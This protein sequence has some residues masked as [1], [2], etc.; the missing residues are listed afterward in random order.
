M[1]KNDSIYA[2]FQRFIGPSKFASVTRK[3]SRLIVA[4]IIQ[5]AYL[6]MTYDWHIMFSKTAH[7][8]KHQGIYIAFYVLPLLNTPIRKLLVIIQQE[9]GICIYSVYEKTTYHIENCT[10]IFYTHFIWTLDWNFEME[11]LGDSN[12]QVSYSIENNAKK[13]LKCYATTYQLG[14]AYKRKNM[15]R[16]A[17][18]A[19]DFLT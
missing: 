10:C 3:K 11:F 7:R 2:S 15:C 5:P 12:I 17:F 6:C 14:V 16:N 4:M 19:T 9:L 1:I 18:M 13:Y 8:P